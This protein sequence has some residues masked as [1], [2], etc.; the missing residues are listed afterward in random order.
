MF[1]LR[2]L[3]QKTCAGQGGRR[4]DGPKVRE[5]GQERGS[6]FQGPTGLIFNH[7]ASRS[8]S[9]TMLKP[10]LAAAAA[11]YCMSAHDWVSVCSRS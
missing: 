4:G 7:G 6:R 10:W 11:T 9:G 3:T 2:T 1:T 8:M 5:V